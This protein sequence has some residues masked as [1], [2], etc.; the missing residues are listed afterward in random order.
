MPEKIKINDE[1]L[2]AQGQKVINSSKAVSELVNNQMRKDMD[3]YDGKFSEKERKYSEILGTSRLFIN[4]TYTNIHRIKIDVLEAHLSDPDEIVA[5]SSW[6]S[7]PYENREITKALINYRLN[8]HPINFYAEDYEYTLD[9]IRVGLGVLKV[10]PKLKTEKVKVPVLMVDPM[11]GQEVQIGEE[12]QEQITA[13][14]PCMNALPPEDVRVSSAAT[15]KDYWKHPIVHRYK[16]KR[17]ECRRLGY[18]NIDEINAANAATSS[19]EV[20]LQRLNEDS[21]LGEETGVKEA[22]EIWVHEIWDFLP[23]KD[24]LE[25]GSY[26]LLGDEEKG[27]VVGRGWEVNELPYKRSEFEYNRPPFFFGFAYPEPHKFKGKS[28]PE[29]TESS[30]KEINAIANQEREGVARALRPLLYVNKDSEV[31]LMALTNRRIGG[32]VQGSGPAGQAIQEVQQ[33]NPLGLTQGQRARVDQ[34]YW[35]A[36]IP[37][38]LLGT[39]SNEETATG[40]NQ[41]L[42]NANKKI[43]DVVRNITYTGLMDALNAL[44]RLEQTYCTD[45]FVRQVTGRVLGWQFANDQYPPREAIQGD[46]DLKINLGVNKQGQL[47][48]IF[49]LLDRITAAN[50]ALGQLV[51]Q[52]VMSP[53]NASFKDPMKVLDMAFPLLG[54]KTADEMNIPAMAPPMDPASAGEVPGLASQ[55][56]QVQD[57]SQTIAQM[58]PE[59]SGAT[60]VL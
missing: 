2:L 52:G 31:D 49:L 32:Y 13:Y 23:G 50:S 34:D 38:N 58:S 30:Q 28:F 16:K 41:Q 6:K 8:S 53:E 35:E 1:F 43:A 18:K 54:L 48:K 4:K 44:L 7:I 27:N 22:E 26:I 9:C 57:P 51:M 14:E 56:R 42:Q 29:I 19:D 24:G 55:P 15:W 5:I 46:F 17:D 33:S 36:G 21:S 20:K 12:E 10:Y 11:T 3:L 60:N 45:D 59:G 37:P 47:N 40:A 39:A 25:S